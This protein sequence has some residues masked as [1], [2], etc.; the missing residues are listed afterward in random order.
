[1]ARTKST[2][3]FEKY[4]A[5]VVKRGGEK[6]RILFELSN[7]MIDYLLTFAVVE[8]LFLPKKS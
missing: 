1:M 4:I 2:L 5:L 3:F 8:P 7:Y 6:M